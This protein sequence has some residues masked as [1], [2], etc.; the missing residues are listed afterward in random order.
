MN[1]KHTTVECT[2]CGQTLGHGK[3]D[4]P[5]CQYACDHDCTLIGHA[6][7]AMKFLNQC[8]E[9][10]IVRSAVEEDPNYGKLWEEF[11]AFAK[12]IGE[13]KR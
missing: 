12:H 5:T 7:E 10:N 9:H 3:G 13:R 1:C 11:T 6:Y 4:H 2:E 8:L